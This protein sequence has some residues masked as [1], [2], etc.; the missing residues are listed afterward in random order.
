[1]LDQDIKVKNPIAAFLAIIIIKERD[2]L[3][4]EI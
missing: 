1:M 3:R 4:P 2:F